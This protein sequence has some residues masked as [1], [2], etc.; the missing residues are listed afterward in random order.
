MELEHFLPKLLEQSSFVIFL[1]VVLYTFYKKDELR[2][3]LDIEERAR[4]SKKSDEQEIR[5]ESYLKEDKLKLMELQIKTLET[6]DSTNTINAKAL[7]TLDVTSEVMN[8]VL[9]EIRNFK[10]TAIFK[11]YENKKV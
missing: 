6:L 9:K 3:K 8:C 4:I 5:I 1:I 11:D 10:A 2:R 7:K